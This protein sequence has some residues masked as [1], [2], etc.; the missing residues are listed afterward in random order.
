MGV[1]L[2]G[3]AQ[4][5]DGFVHLPIQKQ[6]PTQVGV[7]MVILRVECDGLI[8]RGDRSVV[9]LHDVTEK[10]PKC[11]MD[12]GIVRLETKGL[13]ISLPGFLQLAIETEG[14]AKLYLI[15]GFIPVQFDALAEFG[16]GLVQL[17]MSI[18]RLR[19]AKADLAVIRVRVR[20]P[21]SGGNTRRH[22]GCRHCQARG[23]RLPQ[24]L[25]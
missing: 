19:R 6:R 2:D 14:V 3:F 12:V 24:K 25:R 10:T 21:Y 4:G 8:K 1:E 11:M 18:K 23:E 5:S 9:V 16:N 22:D 17:P 20:L 13:L 7:D 15:V